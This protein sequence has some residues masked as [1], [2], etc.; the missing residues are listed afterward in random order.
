M[1]YQ[2]YY[3]VWDNGFNEDKLNDLIADIKDGL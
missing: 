2:N 1:K 3:D